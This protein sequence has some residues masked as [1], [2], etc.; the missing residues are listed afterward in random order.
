MSVQKEG[1]VILKFLKMSK[2][3]QEISALLNAGALAG[4][5]RRTLENLDAPPEK[6]IAQISEEHPKLEI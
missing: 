2:E 5:L 1:N 6:T 3:P 4:H